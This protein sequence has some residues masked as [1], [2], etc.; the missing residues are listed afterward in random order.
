[1]LAYLCLYGSLRYLVHFNSPRRGPA[2]SHF[3]LPLSRFF[4]ADNEVSSHLHPD[5]RH[6]HA[7]YACFTLFLSPHFPAAT[8]AP[9]SNFFGQPHQQQATNVF[10]APGQAQL[11]GLVDPSGLTQDDAVRSLTRLASAYNPASQDYRFQTLF[12]SV[13]ERPEQRVKPPSC[14]DENRWRAALA[15]VKGPNNPQK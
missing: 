6:A 9:T 7:S 3:G 15:A 1:M 5:V 10:G 2:T 14:V 12:V 11:P 8:T 4:T 13:V